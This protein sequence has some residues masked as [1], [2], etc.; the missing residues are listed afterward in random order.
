[1]PLNLKKNICAKWT[2]IYSNGL[3]ENDSRMVA[4]RPLSKWLG[5]VSLRTD[6]F[7]VLGTTYN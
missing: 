2:L 5:I 4:G 1:M 3:E 6:Q 7:G